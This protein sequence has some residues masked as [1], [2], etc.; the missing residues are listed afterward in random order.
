[1]TRTSYLCA[2]GGMLVMSSVLSVRDAAA[3]SVPAA[4]KT[5][6]QT[7]PT[8]AQDRPSPCATTTGTCANAPTHAVELGLE[9]RI[10]RLWSPD[11]TASY[12]AMTTFDVGYL[13]AG[14]LFTGGFVSMGGQ[15]SGIVKSSWSG[16]FRV[17]WLP[18][19]RGPMLAMRFGAD[20]LRLDVGGVSALN[21]YSAT[22][23]F[24][25]MDLG[26][27]VWSACPD[28][29]GP[30]LDVLVGGTA[31]SLQIEHDVAG[32]RNTSGRMLTLGVGI[33]LGFDYA[34]DLH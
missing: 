29:L 15:F 17:A 1:M 19:R 11:Y 32:T 22:G 34:L 12:G 25:A 23:Y 28:L 4:E 33:R 10:S 30:T 31:T 9:P 26:A 27:R 13:Y 16:G 18:I 6:S 24:T 8:K 21:S 20:N 2:T 3:Q 5:R 14:V 7:P